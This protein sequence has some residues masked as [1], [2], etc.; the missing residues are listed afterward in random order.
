MDE[1][2]I[3]NQSLFKS[4]LFIVVI[5]FILIISTFL[6]LI[7]YPWEPDSNIAGISLFV[8][9]IICI[10]LIH[11]GLIFKWITQISFQKDH[12]I[13]DYP[14]RTMRIQY[15]DLGIININ[16]KEW[17]FNTKEGMKVLKNFSNTGYP[18]KEYKS[19]EAFLN[20]EIN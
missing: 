11:Y 17:R 2:K 13:V 6:I 20:T 7:Y 3:K 16:P 10:G 14:L 8:L 19:V 4:T 9:P 12:V 15:E 1:I 5:C 18:P